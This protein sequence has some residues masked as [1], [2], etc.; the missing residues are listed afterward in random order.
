LKENSNQFE[1]ENKALKAT[2]KVAT[3]KNTKLSEALRALKERCFK[4][5]S[6][7][8]ARLRSIFNS[9]GAA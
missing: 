6:K 8:T 2:L 9:V 3:E 7:C 1:Q 5:A 4:F